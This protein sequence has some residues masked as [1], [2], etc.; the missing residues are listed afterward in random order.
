MSTGQIGQ[1]RRGWHGCGHPILWYAVPRREARH[2]RVPAFF[3]DANAPDD[4][5]IAVCPNCLKRLRMADVST[6]RPEEA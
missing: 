5:A 6:T 3:W 4:H 2:C 1:R